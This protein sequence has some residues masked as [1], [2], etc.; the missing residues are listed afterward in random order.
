MYISRTRTDDTLLNVLHYKAKRHTIITNK[1][2]T[3]GIQETI[4]FLMT[5]QTDN[6]RQNA[7]IWHQ[8]H[9]STI[10]NLAA[11]QNKIRLSPSIVQERI[12]Q[13]K[14]CTSTHTIEWQILSARP[15]YFPDVLPTATSTSTINEKTHSIPYT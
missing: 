8:M 4:Y 3:L 15:S 6:A 2:Q 14:H 11:A 7:Q 10:Y 5:T 1:R 12:P 9:S 13:R